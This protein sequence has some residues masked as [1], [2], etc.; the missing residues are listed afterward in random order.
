MEIMYS[1]FPVK[2]IKS[3]FDVAPDKSI[4]HR[5]AI[6]S[7]LSESKTKIHSFL[8]S[9]DT[10]ATLDCL[11]KLGIKF[12]FEGENLLLSGRGKYFFEK[13]EKITLFARESG[14]TMRILTGLLAAQGGSFSFLAGKYLSLRPMGRVVFP[15]RKMGAKIT[16]KKKK[17]KKGIFDVYPPLR[18]DSPPKEIMGIKHNLE[19]ASAQVKSAILLAGLYAKQKTVILEPYQ[20]RNHTE[21]MLQVFG[22]KIVNKGKTVSLSPKSHLRSPREI[23]V[24]S[25]FSSAAFFI[26]LG[27]VTKNSRI[28]IKKVGLNPTRCGLLRALKKMGA[29]IEIKAYKKD[30]EPYG[31]LV[32]KSS[33]LKA[34]TIKPEQIPAMIDEVPILCVAAAFAQG[35]T[36]IKGVK[37]LQVKETN[38]LNSM[39]TNLRRVGV[40]IEIKPFAK[41]D[42]K[43]I[44]KG[45]EKYS[46][47]RFLSYGDH[48]TA[49][50]M[51]IFAL[52]A[53][54]QSQIDDTGCIRKSFP[55]FIK[56]IESLY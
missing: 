32:I 19:V 17:S 35:K 10:L 6:L 46:G 51:I 18:I 2:K 3:S 31:D 25:D 49:M 23:L 37:E 14:T 1:I 28:L 52:A 8:K 42:L 21:Q 5:A 55:G 11:K 4:S 24:P 27:L 16:G 39:L 22:A 47:G 15:L 43:I 48:R 30:V 54:S 41:N 12:Y 34:V 38:R 20:S 33:C 44:I 40:E 45:K 36:E 50:S 56:S 13:K 53:E 9:D 7:A 29:E 26:V